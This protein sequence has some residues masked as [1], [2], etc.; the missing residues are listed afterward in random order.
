M[1]IV[2]PIER[3]GGKIIVYDPDKQKIVSWKK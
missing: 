3:I 1:E 2:E